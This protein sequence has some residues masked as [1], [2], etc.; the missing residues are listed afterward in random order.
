[1]LSLDKV[2]KLVEDKYS[3]TDNNN[4]FIHIKGVVKMATI[5]AQ[6]YNVDQEQAMIA[7]YMHDY[8]KYESNEELEKIINPKDIEE[9]R[10]FPVLYHSYA[11]AES[12]LKH[13]G[14]NQDVYNAIRNHVF[15]RTGMS[16]LEEIIL[17]SDYTEE[18]R[19]YK[20]CIECRDI[21][22]NKSLYE[23]IYFSTKC[24]INFLNKK[25]LEPHP[26]QLEVLKYYEGLC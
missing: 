18:N 12:Y 20:D 6:K 4:R 26:L 1:M 7:A 23:A 13:G 22:F 5:L 25:G 10:K 16:I 8:C 17:I 14:T 24:T 15:G 19:I 3:G 9:C 11:S 21:L 2:Q